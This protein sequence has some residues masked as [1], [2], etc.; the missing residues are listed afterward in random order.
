MTTFLPPLRLTGATLLR[1]GRMQRRSL[2]VEDGLITKGPLPEVDLSGYLILPGIIDLHGDTFERHIAP[3]PSATF[4]IDAALRSTDREAASHGITTAWLAQCWSWEGGMR[5]PDFAEEMMAAIA[6]YRPRAHTDLRLQIRCETH[7]PDTRARL[8]AAVLRHGVD[9]VVFNDH[10][11]EALEVAEREPMKLAHWASR[12]GSSPEEFHAKLRAARAA[13]R[14][15]PRHLCALAELF[16]AHDIRYGS[17]DDPDGET[18]EYYRL[19]GAR[20]AEFPTTVSAAKLARA[21][22]DP[23]LMGAPNVVRGGSQSGNVSARH[24]IAEGLCDALVSDYHY[25]CLAEAA[26]TLVD[27]GLKTLPEAWAM[28]STVPAEI[29]G[30]SDRGTLDHGKRADFVVVD[31]RSRAI[32]ATVSGGRLTYLAGEAG[33]RLV[34]A[35]PGRRLAAE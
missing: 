25:P 33:A 22:N 31:A 19:I 23:V 24:L 17:H 20:I 32:E 6:A 2:V 27:K 5:G 30:L 8:I 16:D 18:R 15:V 29:M 21:C 13:S 14:E 26:W 12:A 3:R 28:I 10:L 34:S 7:M 1:D 4:P 9:Y 35:L 11:P